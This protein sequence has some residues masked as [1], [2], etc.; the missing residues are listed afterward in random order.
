MP[1]KNKNLCVDDVRR[2]EYCGMQETFD[3][4]YQKIKNGEVFKKLMDLMLS[5]DKL[6]FAYRNIKAKGE[7][8]IAGTDKKNITDIGSKCPDEEVEKVR[9]I[10][11]GSTH[12]YRSKSVRRKDL[13]KP[14]EK[15][16]P[17]G[18]PY[19]GNRVI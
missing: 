3:E 11:A 18:I 8:Y 15:T 5:Q 16:R 9:F 1:K 4:L 2:G 10:V 12:G 6:L 19:I 7:S 13:P 17:L 14:N